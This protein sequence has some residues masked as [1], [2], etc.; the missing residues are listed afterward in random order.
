MKFHGLMLV[1][2]EEDILPETIP[3]LLRWIDGLYVLDLGST[4]STWD[5]L[6][7]FAAK[8][9]RVV[10]HAS[11]PIVFNDVLR[12][13]LFD[14]YRNRF[15]SGDWVLRID[16][17]EFYHIPP[18]EFVRQHLRAG[19]TCVHLL[20]Y[21]FRLT[22]QEV[23]AYETGQVDIKQDRLKPIAE[24]RRFYKIPDYA[25]PRMFRYRSTMRWPTNASFPFNAGYV[26]R[27]RIPIRHY[28][29]RDPWQ[30]AKRYQLRAAMMG[31]NAEAGPHWKLDDWRQDVIAADPLSGA[32]IEQNQGG[33]GLAAARGHTAGELHY[34]HP[35]EILPEVH[36]TN[37]LMPPPKRL[38]QRFIHPL[39]L[40]IFDR[41]RPCFPQSFRPRLI[42]D[43]ITKQL[44]DVCSDPFKKTSA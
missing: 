40:P 12:G 32:A 6:Q 34:W 31:L 28:P 7:E 42:P 2:D 4:D 37:H 19:E 13:M 25:E 17:D 20:W 1:R 24:R 18:P 29:H 21:F 23:A 39:C 22:S 27:E 16:A 14:V 41:F 43:E 30:M 35:G 9:P 8:D 11:E 3:H 44:R 5:I 33:V 38:L 10:L 36:T 15:Q 26:A